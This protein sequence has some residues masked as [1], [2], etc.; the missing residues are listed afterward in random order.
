MHA[1]VYT[2]SSPFSTPQLIVFI[3]PQTENMTQSSV[4]TELFDYVIVVDPYTYACII[5][6]DR[7]S[8]NGHN[9]DACFFEHYISI[10]STTH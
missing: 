2:L 5:I 4:L 10:L 8:E 6:W 1:S 9:V 7:C 3:T